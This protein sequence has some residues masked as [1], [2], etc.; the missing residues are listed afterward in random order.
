MASQIKLFERCQFNGAERDKVYSKELDV[1]FDE[2]VQLK[3]SNLLI[4]SS[5]QFNLIVQEKSSNFD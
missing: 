4:I 3:K 1:L 5:P 2:I